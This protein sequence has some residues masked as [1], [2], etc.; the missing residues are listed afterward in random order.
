MDI[1]EREL[2]QLAIQ[3]KYL[4]QTPQ[5]AALERIIELKTQELQNQS[6]VFE[7]DQW[8][9]IVKTIER[10]TKIKTLKNLLMELRELSQ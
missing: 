4:L 1:P 8:I 5:Y 7:T 6:T 2:E 9:T 3:I 10:E